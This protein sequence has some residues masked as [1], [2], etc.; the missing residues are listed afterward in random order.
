[1][2]YEGRNTTMIDTIDKSNQR[3]H[4]LPKCYQAYKQPQEQYQEQ[5]K[6]DQGEP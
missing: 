6:E 2:I 1:M 3:G 4:Q 5:N